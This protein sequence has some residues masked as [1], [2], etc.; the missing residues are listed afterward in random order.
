MLARLVRIAVLI[1]AALAAGGGY[2]A[3]RAY[4]QPLPLASSPFAFEV[5]AGSSLSGVA[6]ELAAAGAL[7]EP[8]SLIALAR[9]RGADRSIKAG[10]YE[11][12]SGTTLP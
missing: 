10:S 4:T 6:R 8:W 1:A 7:R 2:L 9:W 11:L 12:E 3:W 5:R